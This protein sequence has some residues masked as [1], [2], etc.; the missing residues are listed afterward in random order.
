MQVQTSRQHEGCDGEDGQRL[1]NRSIHVT[2][3]RNCNG[4]P[5]VQDD[6][7]ISGPREDP[8]RSGERWQG[9]PV[10][11]RR[12]RRQC[13]LHRTAEPPRARQ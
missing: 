4:D 3:A 6:A 5:G 8:A 13:Q 2:P 9:Q 1:T 7:G 11:K 10:G 12:Q